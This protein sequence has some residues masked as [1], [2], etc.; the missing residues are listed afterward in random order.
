[1]GIDK[2]IERMDSK[3]AEIYIFMKE[4]VNLHGVERVLSSCMF[5]MPNDYKMNL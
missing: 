4:T 5:A 3:I 1:M 2:I